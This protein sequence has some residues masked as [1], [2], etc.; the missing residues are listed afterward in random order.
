[1]L[2]TDFGRIVGDNILVTTLALRHQNKNF[3]R[4]LSYIS[5]NQ[6][7]LFP[8]TIFLYDETNDYVKFKLIKSLNRY[9]NY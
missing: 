9:S 5:V 6:N 2:L 3:L 7:D 1:M 4:I 8:L